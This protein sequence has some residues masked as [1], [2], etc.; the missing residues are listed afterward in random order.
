MKA[1]ISPDVTNKFSISP[2]HSVSLSRTSTE[3]GYEYAKPKYCAHLL[4]KF[5]HALEFGSAPEHYACPD[6]HTPMNALGPDGQERMWI[7][8][9]HLLQDPSVGK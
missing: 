4:G 2:S 8:E 1:A 9:I 5:S 3:A 6:C 7:L